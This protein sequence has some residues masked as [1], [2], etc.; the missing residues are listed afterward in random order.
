[1]LVFAAFTPHSPLL[2]PNIGKENLQKLTQTTEAMQ[3][4][5]EDLYSARPDT[6]IIISGHSKAYPNAFAINLHDT[7]KVDLSA[8]GDLVDQEN[9]YPDLSLIDSIQRQLRLDQ[10][11]FTLHPEETLDHGSAVPLL[12]LTEQIK[13]FKVIPISISDLLP[14]EHFGFGQALK[15]QILHSSRRVAVIASGD[16]SHTLTNESPAGFNANGA[17][18]DKKIQELVTENNAAGLIKMKPEIVKDAAQCGYRALLILFGILDKL[19]FKTDILS[20]EAPLGVGY[21]AVNFELD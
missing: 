13:N 11:P 8:L 14:K 2:L 9:F 20:Y 4:L 3:K 10:V 17:K 12:L 6:I 15:E 5:A 1:M 7:F 19:S 21:L 16:L 18:F